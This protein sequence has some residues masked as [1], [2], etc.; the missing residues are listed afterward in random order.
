MKHLNSYL[1]ILLLLFFNGCS[2][3]GSSEPVSGSSPSSETIGSCTIDI[4]NIYNWNIVSSGNWTYLNNIHSINASLSLSELNKFVSSSTS[5]DC[6]QTNYKV[7]LIKNNTTSN[8]FDQTY[9]SGSSY[10][11][12]WEDLSNRSSIN[13]SNLNLLP[14]TFYKICFYA[15][16]S[17]GIKSKIYCNKDILISDYIPPNPTNCQTLNMNQSASTSFSDAYLQCTMSTIYSS[18]YAFFD[19][20]SNQITSWSVLLGNTNSVFPESE[21]LAGGANYKLGIRLSNSSGYFSTTSFKSFYLPKKI[22]VNI[23]YKTK[24]SSS[25]TISNCQNT[26]KSY[27]NMLSNLSQLYPACSMSQVNSSLYVID[28]TGN[29]IC[30]DGGYCSALNY[31]S[32]SNSYCSS[33][34]LPTQ[35]KGTSY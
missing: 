13:W 12:Q 8:V 20:F 6:V 18:Q 28:C 33:W 35:T 29:Q 34:S 2:A 19:Q 24:T 4:D 27:D 7:A 30:Y 11:K 17:S 32:T 5:A 16:T 23:K 15:A 26:T 22:D 3:G 14:A 31:V 25:S 10:A 9:F 1:S 21:G